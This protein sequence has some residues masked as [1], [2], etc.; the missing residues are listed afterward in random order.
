MEEKITELVNLVSDKPEAS[1]HLRVFWVT[2]N[3]FVR[4]YYGRCSTSVYDKEYGFVKDLTYSSISGE[5]RG[6]ILALFSKL[7]FLINELIQLKLLGFNSRNGREL[8]DLLEEVSFEKRTRLLQEWSII[9]EKLWG[10]IKRVTEVRNNLAHVY[11]IEKISYPKKISKKKSEKIPLRQV[12]DDFKKD[13]EEVWKGLIEIYQEKQQ[14][15]GGE[16]D[17]L[18]KSIRENSFKTPETAAGTV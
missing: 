1:L 7:E 12:F 2:E 11:N 18:I 14:A 8:D 9:D 16:L 6:K 4:I 10:K 13:F 15:F 5:T 17:A 3:E